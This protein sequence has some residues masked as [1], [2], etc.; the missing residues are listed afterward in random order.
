MYYS[1]YSSGS[2]PHSTQ[3]KIQKVS[4]YLRNKANVKLV[5]T[6]AESYVLVIL[7]PGINL[8]SRYIKF[9]G[10]S[11]ISGYENRRNCNYPMLIMPIIKVII[12][13][14]SQI[15]QMYILVT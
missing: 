8:S 1:K 13:R 9:T 6:R 4:S 7:G 11:G 3:S 15:R 5:L 12:I 2:D 14:L 10:A